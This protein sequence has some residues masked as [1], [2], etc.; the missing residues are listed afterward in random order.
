MSQ[1]ENFSRLFESPEPAAQ[2][3]GIQDASMPIPRRAAGPFQRCGAVLRRPLAGALLGVAATL[4]VPYAMAAESPEDVR[5]PVEQAQAAS[6]NI[7]TASVEE[8]AQNLTG[9]GG[10]KAEAIV[11]YREQFGP[12]ESVEELAEVTG[13][14]SSTVERNRGR[15]RLR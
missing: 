14:G 1:S 10:S 7:N 15:I 11:R 8:L 2:T 5:S 13:I 3:T 6:V 4:A 9:V 12:F